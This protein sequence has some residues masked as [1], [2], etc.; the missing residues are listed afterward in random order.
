ML[1]SNQTLSQLWYIASLLKP[2][3]AKTENRQEWQT[4][5]AFRTSLLIN[6]LFELSSIEE[7]K[8]DLTSFCATSL[9]SEI[10]SILNSKTVPGLFLK[11]SEPSGPLPSLLEGLA[12]S[13]NANYVWF[14]PDCHEPTICVL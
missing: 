6:S 11:V 7:D 9:S 5:L 13:S 3:T 2:N 12:L 14:L 1:I 4:D 8:S 10:C